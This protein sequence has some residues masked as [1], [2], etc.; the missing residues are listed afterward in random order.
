M[1]PTFDELILMSSKLID[2]ARE[3]AVRF[4][5][6][7]SCTGGLASAMIT[8]VSGSSDVYDGGV[9]TY[10]N[11]IKTKLIGVDPSTL[12]Q[13]GAVSSETAF[14]MSEGVLDLMGVDIAISITGIAG[15]GGA[16]KD[17]PVG[18][19]WFGCTHHKQSQTYLK[20]FEGNR[21]EVRR[22]SV[23]FAFSLL[24]DALRAF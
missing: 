20:H 3:K 19:V 18:T 8:E 1:T 5:F 16:Q 7:E 17:K 11:R 15:P 10:A 14:E 21:S 23:A 2:L 13:H 22:Q 4:T 6:A 9:C 12:S 24:E